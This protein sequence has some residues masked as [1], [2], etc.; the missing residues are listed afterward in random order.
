MISLFRLMIADSRT[1]FGIVTTCDT[2]ANGDL[3]VNTT[4]QPKPWASNEFGGLKQYNSCLLFGN[5][6]CAA[7][8]TP[9]PRKY[10]EFD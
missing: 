4:E 3:R 7:E 1:E 2:S 6:Q 8:G 10:P 5:R 9:N